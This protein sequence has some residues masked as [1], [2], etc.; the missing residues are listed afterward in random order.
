[1]FRIKSVLIRL[2][3]PG[4]KFVEICVY[5]LIASHLCRPMR[6]NYHA[7]FTQLKTKIPKRRHRKKQQQCG[8][9]VG[10][11]LAFNSDGTDADGQSP[12]DTDRT[13]KSE[14]LF[15]MPKPEGKKEG[16]DERTKKE[17]EK[18]RGG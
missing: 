17:K 13:Q 9:V 6:W 15:F 5:K 14:A 2:R 1:M 11:P 12:T 3:N 10:R 4:Y 7:K 8:A 18:E 16:K